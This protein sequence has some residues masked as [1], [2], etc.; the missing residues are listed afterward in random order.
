MAKNEGQEQK[1]PQRFI[2]ST[3]YKI[4]VFILVF[5]AIVVSPIYPEM[6]LRILI[7]IILGIGVFFGFAS[8]ETHCKYVYDLIKIR[9][10]IFDIIKWSWSLGCQPRYFAMLVSIGCY[11]GALLLAFKTKII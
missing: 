4:C 11:L 1:E 9:I 5:V 6:I 8:D 2:F 7:A 3:F 10:N